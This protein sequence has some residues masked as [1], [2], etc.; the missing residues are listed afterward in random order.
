MNPLALI[1]MGVGLLLIVIGF[2]GSQ[3]HV[4]TA[5]KGVKQGQSTKA[6]GNQ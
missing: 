2:T 4:M 6:M 1:I 3:H 5:F